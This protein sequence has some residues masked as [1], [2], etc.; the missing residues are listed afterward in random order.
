[1]EGEEGKKFD[2]LGF[3]QPDKGE[4]LA[5][6][7]SPE[8][9]RNL[10]D[11]ITIIAQAVVNKE[12]IAG[13]NSEQLGKLIEEVK[14]IK[15]GLLDPQTASDYEENANRLVEIIGKLKN[16]PAEVS[17]ITESQLPTM[18][19]PIV[20]DT[21]FTAPI[22]ESEQ[23]TNSTRNDQRD[24]NAA[25]NEPAEESGASLSGGESTS[26]MRD[27]S[28]QEVLTRVDQMEARLHEVYKNKKAELDGR[29][30]QLNAEKEQLDADYQA[31][32]Q[33]LAEGKQKLKEDLQQIIELAA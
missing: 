30:N 24:P 31:R 18:Q 22:A 28:P 2:G 4:V 5:V 10:L 12:T 21:A 19:E 25:P 27:L 26:D 32:I 17:D 16:K 15:A 1:M 6:E 13:W 3:Y 33:R 20:E 8:Q 14:Q 7:L 11:K 23:V 9:Q 29:Q